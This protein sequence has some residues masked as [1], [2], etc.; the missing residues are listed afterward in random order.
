M[1]FIRVEAWVES[2]SISKCS[3]IGLIYKWTRVQCVSIF[4]KI[5]LYNTWIDV[6]SGEYLID[7]SGNNV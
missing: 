2:F 3:L 5:Y 4:E 6:S 1:G 7:A